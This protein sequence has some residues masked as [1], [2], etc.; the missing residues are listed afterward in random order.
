[1]EILEK[2]FGS[3]H[4][5][6]TECLMGLTI[7]YLESGYFD[8]AYSYLKRYL[9]LHEKR[10]ESLKKINSENEVLEYNFLNDC[11]LKHF[12]N[13]VNQKFPNDPMKTKEA[14]NIWLKSKGAVL[15]VK[16]KYQESLFINS[17]PATDEIL[18][19]ISNIRDNLSKLAFSTTF[20]DEI[21]SFKKQKNSLK[22]KKENLDVRLN[23][24]IHAFSQQEVVNQDSE[25]IAKNLPSGTVLL[26]FV[27]ADCIF[28]DNEKY[29][30]FIIHSGE[31]EKVRLIDLGNIDEIDHLI[32]GYKKELSESGNGDGSIPLKTAKRLYDLVFRP[33]EKELGEAKNIFISPDGNLNLI[34]FEVLQNPDGKYLIEEYTFNYL[35]AGRDLLAFKS[36]TEPGQKYV[37]MGAPD[38][39]LKPSEKQNIIKNNNIEENRLTASRAANLSELSFEPLY[40]AKAELKAIGDIMG[41]DKCDIFT[42]PNALEE[43]LFARQSHEILHLATHG[44]FLGDE[45]LPSSGRGWEIATFPAVKETYSEPID[46]LIDIENPL[47]RSGIL[48]AGAKHSLTTGNAGINDGIVTAEKILGMNLHGTKMVVLSAC[49]TGLG[50]VRS[51]EGVFGLR[52]AFIQAGAKSLVMSMWKV[53]DRETK[54]M[55]VQFYQNIKSGMDRCQALRDAALKQIQIVQQRYGHTNP[56]HWGAFVF[57]GEP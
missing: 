20:V 6:L 52:R 37:L 18:Y 38:F 34:P 32:A 53:P 26:D 4:S 1:M 3:N 48:L 14:F 33:L 41:P 54:E 22:Y 11:A 15:E 47:L 10:I 16:K 17:N 36:Y 29:L 5:K 56:R 2:R 42:G 45:T 44:F 49:D 43:I 12:I 51:G 25:V 19:E 23:Y 40:H 28:E 31:G 21:E 24:L 9:E 35:V 27:R 46:R 8:N 50:E 30:S 13:L 7:L 57:M 39:D 55:M